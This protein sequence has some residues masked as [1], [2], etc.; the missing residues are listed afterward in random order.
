[1]K[2]LF[3]SSCASL[4]ATR[5]YG[6]GWNA[7]IEDENAERRRRAS[8][9]SSSP[10]V[11]RVRAKKSGFAAEIMKKRTTTKTML[12]A[13]VRLRTV[14]RTKLNDV[15][16]VLPGRTSPV[17]ARITIWHNIHPIQ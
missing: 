17:A 9:S 3:S 1:M 12:R 8:P 15:R 11:V 7:R 10:A 13:R 2:T 4:R 6:A 16:A 5:H 14:K